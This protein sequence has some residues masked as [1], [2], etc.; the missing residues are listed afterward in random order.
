MKTAKTYCLEQNK[1][2]AI[3]KIKGEEFIESQLLEW[4]ERTVKPR[5]ESIV[6][7]T[8]YREVSIQFPSIKDIDGISV[9]NSAQLPRIQRLLKPKG[10]GVEFQLKNGSNV[11]I[12]WAPIDWQK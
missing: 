8:N 4:I 9:H 3:K 10:F 1:R 5:V 11:N 12:G 2:L 7:T 6:K